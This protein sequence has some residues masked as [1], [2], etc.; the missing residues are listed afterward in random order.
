MDIR[1]GVPVQAEDGQAGKVERIILHPATNEVDSIVAVQGWLLSRDVV[2]PV[3]RILA[4]DEEGVRV[5]G[6]AEEIDNLEP[7]AQSQYTDPPEDWLAPND[8]PPAFFLFP[9]SPYAVGAFAPSS[10]AL[11]PAEREVENLPPGDVEVSGTTTV[12][13][14]DG[15]G[16]TLT[17]V[18]TE[19]DTDKVIA[20]VVRRGVLGHRDLR[21]P[22]EH[23]H[24]MDS[25]GIRLTLTESELD[26]LPTL[27]E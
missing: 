4:A 19:G 6:T 9:A 5:R 15:V 10:G 18:V 3:D 23:V 11:E 17:R 21:V 25:E 27:E 22:V 13:C 20:V 24:S 16:G 14:A 1:I 7:F 2:I 26:K 8:M 12:Y